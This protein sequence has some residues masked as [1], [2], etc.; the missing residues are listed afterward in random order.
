[1]SFPTRASGLNVKTVDD[2][3]LVHD[4]RKEKVHVLNLSAGRVLELADG[5]RDVVKI[6][7]ELAD[8]SSAQVAIVQPEVEAILKAFSELELVN[9]TS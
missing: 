4:P 1:M 5:S 7:Q 3:V 8:E 2:Q 9:Y 6:S